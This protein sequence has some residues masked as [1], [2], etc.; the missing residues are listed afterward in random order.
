MTEQSEEIGRQR[1]Y[2]RILSP[3]I[4]FAWLLCGLGAFALLVEAAIDRPD[5]LRDAYRLAAQEAEA[6]P[7]VLAALGTPIESRTIPSLNIETGPGYRHVDLTMRLSGPRAEGVL[8]ARLERNYGPW[9]IESMHLEIDD[10]PT[11]LELR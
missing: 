4:V 1:T 5:G 6:H 2:P 3:E 7:T 11:T 10:E 8:R 9:R